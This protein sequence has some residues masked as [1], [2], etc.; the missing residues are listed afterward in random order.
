MNNAKP[1]PPRDRNGMPRP[2][3][4]VRV[5]RRPK[6]VIPKLVRE[7]MAMLQPERRKAE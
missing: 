4:T 5:Q 6:A 7:M 2:P 3:L 1:T